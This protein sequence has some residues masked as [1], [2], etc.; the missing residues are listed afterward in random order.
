LGLCYENGWGITKN[1]E[2]A[3]KL[4]SKAAEAGDTQAQYKLGLC[5]ENGWGITK[6][7]EKAFKLYSKAAEAG[8]TQA[9]YK[10]GLC[11]ENGWG[12]TKNLEKAFKLYSKA[13][14][15]GNT[16]AQ[17]NLWIY[18][19]NG[20]RT[21][22]NFEDA[23]E[24]FYYQNGWGTT[25]NLEKAFEIYSKAAEAKNLSYRSNFPNL[26][27]LNLT[28]QDQNDLEPFFDQLSDD[29]KCLKCGNLGII[30]TGSPICPFCD[31]NV[32]EAGLPKCSECYCTLKNPLWCNA[33][34]SSRLSKRIMLII[35]FHYSHYHG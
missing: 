10:L 29:F 28:L 9:Q 19:Q 21:T 34:E 18:H 7:L 14:K 4:Y 8:D 6:N 5:Y 15:A 30:I 22:K 24:L 32:F 2:K 11:Y 35:S 25:K 20:W 26:N 27:A 17:H 12:I 33:C 1:L 13:A 16:Q 23:F 3:F 31:N